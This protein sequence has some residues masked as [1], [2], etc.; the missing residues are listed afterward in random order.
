MLIRLLIVCCLSVE[1]IH[2]AAHAQTD[3]SNVQSSLNELFSQSYDDASEPA[4]KEYTALHKLLVL[5]TK[6]QLP[7]EQRKD[8]FKKNASLFSEKY[9]KYDLL[10]LAAMG[11]KAYLNSDIISLKSLL[12]ILT[13]RFLQKNPE[14]ITTFERIK[15]IYPLFSQVLSAD[16]LAQS[17]SL[18]KTAHLMP[19]SSAVCSSW[20]FRDIGSFVSVAEKVALGQNVADNLEEL[21]SKDLLPIIKQLVDAHEAELVKI[22][23]AAVK[24]I[25]TSSWCVL[26]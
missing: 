18:P 15:Y 19:L 3:S 24:V 4:S 26:L 6:Q 21:F 1:T 8:F 14:E 20:N 23:A 2:S 12:Y 22:A 11:N 16:I 13:G 9:N 17:N 7:Q 5:Q 25:E 10:M